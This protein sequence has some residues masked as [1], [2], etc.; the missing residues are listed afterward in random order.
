MDRP[1]ALRTKTRIEARSSAA[2]GRQPQRGRQAVAESIRA[3]GAQTKIWI[4][5]SGWSYDGW[6]G[7]LYPESLP[8]KNWLRYYG[9]EFSSAEIN[10]SF[11]RTP[12]EEAVR[13]W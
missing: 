5:T 7:A 12:S 3:A 9:K 6:R 13:A 2:Q 10:A 8:K 4:G 11:Y 1:P